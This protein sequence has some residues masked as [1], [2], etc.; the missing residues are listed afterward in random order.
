MPA[1][2]GG[3]G[4]SITDVHTWSIREYGRLIGVFRLME[5]LEKHGMRGTVALNSEFCRYYPEIIEEGNKLGWEWMGHN[6][7]N[8]RRL[9]VI[10]PE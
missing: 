5:V 9:N 3:S 8:T 6:Q 1:G 2:P 10:P 7:P 4:R